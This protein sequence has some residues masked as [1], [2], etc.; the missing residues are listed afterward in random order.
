MKHIF[1]HFSFALIPLLG[2]S[3]FCGCS[4]QTEKPTNAV[5][6]EKPELIPTNQ[7][8]P[9]SNE[10]LP[11]TIKLEVKDI[12]IGTKYKT[13]IRQLGKPL[14][15]K[16]GGENPCG[17][18]KLVLKYSGLEVTFDVESENDR[19][20]IVV[21]V[22]VSSPKLEVSGI[23]IGASLEDVRAKFGKSSELRKEEGFDNIGYFVKDGYANFYFRNDKLVKITW[24]LNM[25]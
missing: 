2:I 12:D 17:G 24:E 19:N 25:C 3:S 1:R 8:E 6:S 4:A 21:F 14:S 7:N 13:V 18:E 10:E 9:K 16:K 23:K 22:E 20:P 5:Q 11:K 15:S